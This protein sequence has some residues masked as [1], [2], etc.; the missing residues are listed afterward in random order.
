MNRGQKEFIE[1]FIKNSMSEARCV[2]MESL[3]FLR[4]L[5]IKNSNSCDDNVSICGYVSTTWNETTLKS[6]PLTRKRVWF[7]AFTSADKEYN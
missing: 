2:I 1:F 7:L 4:H 6:T 5:S 3:G